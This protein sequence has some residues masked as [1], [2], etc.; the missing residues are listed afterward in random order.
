MIFLLLRR[1]EWLES[2]D[3]VAEP[4]AEGFVHCCDER[5]VGGVRQ[6]YFAPGDDVVVLAVDPT[7]LDAETR[8]EAGSG[9]EPERFPHV[10]GAITRSS[11]SGVQEA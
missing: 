9:G 6:R 2:G 8:Y 5:Q 10:Y 11:V 1:N 7:L 3:V 4:G